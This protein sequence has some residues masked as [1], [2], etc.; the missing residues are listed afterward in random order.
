MMTIELEEGQRQLLLM[1]LVVLAE[2]RP[3]WLPAAIMPIV[4]KLRGEEMFV[5]LKKFRGPTT[6]ASP[7]E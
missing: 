3:G 5:E 1:A 6:P 2:E 4:G 7:P